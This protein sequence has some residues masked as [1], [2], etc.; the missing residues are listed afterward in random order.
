MK[1]HIGCGPR[2]LQ[3]W[4]NLD[5]EPGPGGVVYDATKPLPYEDQS[6]SFIYSE[7]FI[8][9]LDYHSALA[10]LKDCF[11]VLKPAGA[12]RVSTP[13]LFT[14]TK[15]YLEQSTK[16]YSS[17]GWLPETPCKM[18]NEGMRSWGHV[19]LYDEDELATS[20]TKAGFQFVKRAEYRKS[21][22][23]ELCDLESRPPLDD[24]IIEGIRQ[25]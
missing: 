20:F 17:V 16:F 15:A 24:L 8:E 4:V 25:K 22:R 1:L 19:F 2:I 5:L 10:H 23:P 11:R 13:D 3:G 6:V 21:T 12:L 14:L 7:H 9:H 18:F